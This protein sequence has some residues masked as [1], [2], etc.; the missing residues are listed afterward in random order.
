MQIVYRQAIHATQARTLIVVFGGF[1]TIEE[2][3]WNVDCKEHGGYGECEAE[4]SREISP[5]YDVVL[6]YDY[7]DLDSGAMCAQTASQQRHATA[8]ES[9]VCALE[10]RMAGYERCMLVA[11]S[12][13]VCV[14]PRIFSAR[15]L[16]LWERFSARIAVNGTPLG[17]DAQQGIHP[18]IY[19]HTMKRFSLADFARALFGLDSRTNSTP[20]SKSLALCHALESRLDTNACKRELE[21]LYTLAT[22]LAHD[23]AFTYTHALISTH[24]SI[25]P[26]ESVRAYCSA[27]TP[28]I[29][30][31]EL[32]APHFLFH[33]FASWSDVLRL[34]GVLDPRHKSTPAPQKFGKLDSRLPESAAVARRF[35]A[36]Q[37]S[38]AQHARI[39]AHM[40]E[41]LIRLLLES[42]PN[43]NGRR[44]FARIFEFG[45]GGGEFSEILQ[46]ELVYREFIC[47]DIN[48]FS[49][50]WEKRLSPA[51]RAEIFDMRD[52]AR[53]SISKERFNLIASNACLQWL[54]SHETLPVL[55]SM[56]EEHGVL[57]LGSFGVR[58]CY[59]IAYTLGVSLEYQGEDALRSQLEALG[60]QVLHISTEVQVLDFGS[61]S[62]VFR[63][64]RD[65]GVNSLNATLTKSKL[66]AYEQ[67]FGA[68]LT[69][70]PI[71]I[72]AQ[73]LP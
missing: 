21:S 73:K 2:M 67:M 51:T 60:L 50:R 53:H 31:Y 66:L 34:C 37:E 43:H 44:E 27:H 65:S 26:R 64:L 52:L 49:K 32:N 62:G 70:E 55:A 28:P 40:R 20:E 54:D 8:L 35:Y 42:S 3:F 1:A 72:L 63:H 22:T 10:K 45:A 41:K 18:K 17:I 33:L 12:L 16:G 36:A 19:T 13:G 39:Q 30:Y 46:R 23:P 24:D 11:F 15:G 25:F 5:V 4:S 48:D 57:V 47:S 7:G 71:Y 56:L 38:Y 29:P 6:C 58:N 69:Y 14:A 68:R 9:I 59:E 61:A